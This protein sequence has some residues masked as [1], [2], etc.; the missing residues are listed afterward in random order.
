M[1]RDGRNRVRHHAVDSGGDRPGSQRGDEHP[2]E[3]QH[4]GSPDRAGSAAVDEGAVGATAVI[5]IRM[6]PPIRLVRRRDSGKTLLVSRLAE[7][8]HSGS[9]GKR[10]RMAGPQ[11]KNRRRKIRLAE[12]IQRA[13]C[14]KRK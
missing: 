3:G 7:P 9:R 5:S 6:K 13:I 2:Q 1:Q 4:S 10:R 8:A 12:E 14:T 11:R